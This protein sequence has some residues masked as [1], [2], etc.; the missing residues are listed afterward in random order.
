M[1][2]SASA[3]GVKLKP[4]PWA[5]FFWF[6]VG[7]ISKNEMKRGRRPTGSVRRAGPVSR[8]WLRRRIEGLRVG[9]GHIDAELITPS[10]MKRP[11][12]IAADCLTHSRPT[13]LEYRKLNPVQDY[14]R[15]SVLEDFVG[16]SGHT[17]LRGRDVVDDFHR[18]R[19]R[20]KRARVC[21]PVSRIG[22]ACEGSV[23]L[24]IAGVT[25]RKIAQF[26]AGVQECPS[27]SP[28]FFCRQGMSWFDS[29]G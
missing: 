20:F 16:R 27:P 24:T 18:E 6:V 29:Q 28:G 25:D 22:K 17:I 13:E 4:R 9:G 23:V 8:N 15:V 5:R 14:V 3:F 7:I 21:I 19:G 1:A 11:V 2:P 10:P 26:S 12:H